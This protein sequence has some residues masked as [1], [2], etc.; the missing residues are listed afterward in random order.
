MVQLENKGRVLLSKLSKYAYDL[1]LIFH[2]HMNGN[3]YLN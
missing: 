2:L 3:S 1:E